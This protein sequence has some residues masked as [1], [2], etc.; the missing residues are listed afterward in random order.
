[1][2]ND[3][4]TI[5]LIESACSARSPARRSSTTAT[6]SAWA[7]T[8]IWATATACGRRCSGPP[9]ATPVSRS[10]DPARLYAPVGDRSRYMATRPSTSRRS[11]EQSAIVLVSADQ[12]IDRGA[13]IDIQRL[14]AARMELLHPPRQPIGTRLYSGSME[15]ERHSLR[16][17]SVAIGTG[18]RAR[19][20][21]RSGI[22]F[23]SRCSAARAFPRSA[24]CPT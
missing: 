10:A 23:R 20:C 4:R 24:N 2:G 22:V 11:R 13:Q 9:T 1:M 16:R 8:S 12:T 15:G 17:Q 7:T 21:R 3:R 19:P 5:E 18:D 6:K 14:V